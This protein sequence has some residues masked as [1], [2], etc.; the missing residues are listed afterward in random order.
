[1]RCY[2]VGGGVRGASFTGA[3]AV[4]VGALAKLARGTIDDGR[5][6]NFGKK[7][8]KTRESALEC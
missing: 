3:G 5:A 8:K 2:H 4:E 6:F 7:K 1:M